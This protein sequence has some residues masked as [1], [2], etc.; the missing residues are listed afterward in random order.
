MTQL[1]LFSLL[2]YFSGITL[3]FY[4][5]ALPIRANIIC[6]LVAVALLVLP[7]LAT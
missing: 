5:H 7:S 6:F 2:C 1:E 3:L 4:G